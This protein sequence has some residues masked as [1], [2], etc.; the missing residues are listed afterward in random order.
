MAQ[1]G[2][3]ESWQTYYNRQ[4]KL[5]KLRLYFC[6]IAW[7]LFEKVF[8]DH[9]IHR[10]YQEVTSA[11]AYIQQRLEAEGG[12]SELSLSMSS[13]GKVPSYNVLGLN[14]NSLLNLDIK[15]ELDNEC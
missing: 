2:D 5:E 4:D 14:T 12:L 6:V 3:L 13:M 7:Q 10:L 9:K 8:P 1:I 11:P 15:T